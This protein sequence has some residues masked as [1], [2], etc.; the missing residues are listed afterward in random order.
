MK[1]SN[2]VTIST[3]YHFYSSKLIITIIIILIGLLYIC[4]KMYE[5]LVLVKASMVFAV[6]YYTYI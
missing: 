3:N 4:K 1:Y 2:D 6:I 5:Q